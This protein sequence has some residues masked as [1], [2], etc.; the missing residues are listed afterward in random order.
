MK[1]KAKIHQ[2]SRQNQIPTRSF[3]LKN[4]AQVNIAALPPPRVAVLILTLVENVIKKRKVRKKIR[5]QLTQTQT[6]TGLS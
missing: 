1:K 3:P 5:Q 6:S 2:N 4:I